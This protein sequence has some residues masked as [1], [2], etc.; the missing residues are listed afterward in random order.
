[1]R[2]HSLL[3]EVVQEKRADGTFLLR[4]FSRFALLIRTWMN[5]DL[6]CQRTRSLL[7]RVSHRLHRH[8]HAAAE[9]RGRERPMR[10]R[11]NQQARRRVRNGEYL[12][13][14]GC[15]SD[16]IARAMQMLFKISGKITSGESKTTNG[17][18]HGRCGSNS[19]VS[20][21]FL[22]GES[23]GKTAPSIPT[24]AVTKRSPEEGGKE[25]G[26]TDDLLPRSTA[27]ACSCTGP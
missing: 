14:S 11:R 16:S 3:K 2:R 25:T 22:R 8:P 10:A 15:D 26:A 17:V 20:W 21:A 23:P 4:C 27:P 1:M 13:H 18:E 12:A 9:G 24:N 7:R 5:G 19:F 6:A